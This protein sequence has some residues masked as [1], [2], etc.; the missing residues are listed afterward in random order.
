MSRNLCIKRRFTKLLLIPHGVV[1]YLIYIHFQREIKIFSYCYWPSEKMAQKIYNLK[2]KNFNENVDF[3][4][5]NLLSESMFTDVILVSDDK[6]VFKA[7][8]FVLSACSQVLKDILINHLHFNPIVY[9]RGIH[10]SELEAILDFLYLGK[11]ELY[12]SRKNK[13]FEVD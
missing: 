1:V 12:Q 8:K 4:M 2:W 13:I 7:H 9:L 6:K 11:T 5:K 10:S 3:N